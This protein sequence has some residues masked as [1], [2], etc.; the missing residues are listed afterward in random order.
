[1]T[2]Q[3][4][5]V[6]QSDSAITYTL[7]D[8]S[9]F[10]AQFRAGTLRADQVRA[11]FDRLIASRAAVVAELGKRTMAKLAP[12][13]RGTKAQA[14]DTIFTN[15]MTSHLIERSYQWNPFG[16]TIEAAI[17][18]KLG[19]LTD[20]AIAAD[21]ERRK[22]ASAET[23]RAIND[24]VTLADFRVYR[25]HKGGLDG[26]PAEKRALYDELVAAQ[27]RAEIERQTAQRATVRAVDVGD[28]SLNIIETKHTQ[29]G[30]DLYVVQLSERVER[31]RYNELNIAARRLGGYYS[32]FRGNGAVPGFQ[33]TT[34]KD[35][36]TF[37]GLAAGKSASTLDRIQAR[38]A[39]LQEQAVARLRTVAR[40]LRLVAEASTRSNRKVNTLR[41]VR[42]AASAEARA[43]ADIAMADTLQALAAAIEAG[44]A[45]HL[46][47][48]R[49][50]SDVEALEDIL[51]SG[52][53][54]R[55]R[56]ETNGRRIPAEE[57]GPLGSEDIEAIAFPMPRVYVEHIDA[58][59]QAIANQRGDMRL[60][61]R[62]AKIV[63]V[64]RERS[65]TCF[66]PAASRIEDLRDLVRAA[67]R[68]CPFAAAAISAEIADYDRLQRLHLPNLPTLRAALR[69]LLTYR[70]TPATPDPIV[71]AERALVGR[72]IFGFVPTP[73]ALSADLVEIL[74]PQ[75]GEKVLE[76]NGGTGRLADA[77]ARIVGA[78]LVDVVELVDDLRAVLEAKGY[79]LVGRDFAEYA[80][81]AEGYRKIIMNPPFEGG[82]DIAHI[83]RAAGMLAPGGRLVAICGEG[84]FYRQD[85]AA[86]EFR[87]WL[88]GAGAVVDRL[89]AGSFAESGTGVAAR[90]VIIDRSELP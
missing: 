50:R 80:A 39:T 23:L 42:M 30:H 74:A 17:K 35:A 79:R 66:N 4:I 41:R 38:E 29:K 22:V 21:V 40:R 24:P 5:L 64:A 2:A 69:E 31:D 52:R 87:D 43:A 83:R 15:M 46:E 9:E 20:E 47:R 6:A 67:R 25:D 44:Q 85:R 14:I 33:F 65:V 73:A 82:T 1:M 57:L 48:L 76:P 63:R 75:P 90:V 59:A 55:S 62:W 16:E 36:E 68:R 37:Q 81:P 28:V 86:C 18:R 51:R 27:T 10:M 84:A 19:D 89:P 58:M 78:D 88:D 70:G 60:A 54:A 61:A 72:R 32:S 8:H 71:A 77:V 56:R 11:N 53:Y 45:Q 13:F 3:P 34:R 49:F 12:G 7:A 26:L